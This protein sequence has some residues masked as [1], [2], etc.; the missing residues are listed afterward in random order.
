MLPPLGT[1]GK[2][3]LIL[4]L[5]PEPKEKNSMDLS[6]LH[7]RMPV[8]GQLLWTQEQGS[9]LPGW[10]LRAGALLLAC[11]SI[12]LVP[13][14]PHPGSHHRALKGWFCGRSA[15]RSLDREQ[16]LTVQLE[17]ASNSDS[18]SL[19]PKFWGDRCEPLCLA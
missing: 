19:P 9:R 3:G 6:K 14:S 1:W 12:L 11:P 2:K 8:I 7:L 4:M 15:G 10:M 17:L 16:A 13:L 5:I 18:P